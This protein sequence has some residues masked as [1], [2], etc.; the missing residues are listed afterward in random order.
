MLFGTVGDG[1]SGSR[2]ISPKCFFLSWPV[3]TRYIC[4][5]GRMPASLSSYPA[6]VPQIV[7]AGPLAGIHGLIRCDLVASDPGMTALTG[8]APYAGSGWRFTRE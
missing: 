1:L 4:C 6:A 3:R 8:M 7:A 2:R 5:V